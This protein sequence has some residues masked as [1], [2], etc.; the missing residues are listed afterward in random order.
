MSD[1]TYFDDLD[2][3]FR[4]FNSNLGPIICLLRSLSSSSAVNLSHVSMW[5]RPLYFLLHISNTNF[6]SC[7]WQCSKSIYS[8][9]REIL[10]PP[11]LKSWTCQ[12][13]SILDGSILTAHL[14]ELALNELWSLWWGI[15]ILMA[16]HWKSSILGA[17]QNTLTWSVHLE[18]SGSLSDIYYRVLNLGGH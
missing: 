14:F 6:L 15:S 7:K 9:F 16:S 8:Q 10:L 2:H 12:V 1:E 17:F 4:H 11:V 13:K 3:V 18:K 5:H